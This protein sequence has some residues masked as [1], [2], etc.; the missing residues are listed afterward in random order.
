MATPANAV[1]MG[2]QALTA[3]AAGTNST[4]GANLSQTQGWIQDSNSWT[5]TANTTFTIPGNVTAVYGPA[6]AV[7]WTETSVQKYGIVASSSFSGGTTTVTLASTSDYVM[8]ANPDAGSNYYSFGVP[9]DFP[10]AFTWS[11]AAFSG[12]ASAPTVTESNFTLKP[13][14]RIQVCFLLVGTSNATTMTATLP[15]ASNPLSQGQ[16]V[17]TFVGFDN[18]AYCQAFCSSAASSTTL[19][20]NKAVNLLSSAW[21]ASNDKGGVGTFEYGV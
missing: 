9:R 14:R 19:T 13:G 8:A 20:F 18:N 15:I 6:V 10:D 1:N 16:S 21:T 4:D 12:F 2:S 3:L 17:G 11:G 7:K 5:R